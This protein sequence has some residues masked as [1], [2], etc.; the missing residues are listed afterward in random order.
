MIVQNA[1]NEQTKERLA[2]LIMIIM[3]LEDLTEENAFESIS[4]F[5]VS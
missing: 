4:R 2:K 5:M 3:I 1:E